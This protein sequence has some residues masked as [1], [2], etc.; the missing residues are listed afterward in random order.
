MS[1]LE[2]S[3]SQF[4]QLADR[5]STL[6]EQWLT[7]L[8]ARSVAPATTGAS[9]QALFAE[10]LPEAGLKDA[11]LEGLG[12]V[13]A[14][15]RAGNARFLGYVCGSGEPVGALGDYLASVLNQNVTAWRSAPAMVSLERSVVAGLARAVGCEGFTG[16]F[17]GGGSAAN[18]MGLAMAREARAP[19]NEDGASGGVVYA[20]S[21][22]HMS[23]PKAMAL[24]GLGRKN[25]RLIPTDAKWRMRP[26]VL[27]RA[28]T[29]DLAAGRRPLAVVATAG[30]VHT[31]AVDPLPDVARIA[32]ARNL[33]LHVD[34]AYGAFAAMA[35][36]E[37]FEGLSLADSLSMDAHKWLYQPVDCGVLLF[38]DAG[39]AR[40]AFSFSGDYARVMSADAVEGFAFFDESLELSR[41]ARALKV[42]LSVRYHGLAA[43]REAILRDVENARR[44]EFAV[45]TAPSLQLLA[46]ATLSAVC[47]RYAGAVP[48]LER[49][50]FNARLLVRVNARGRVYL[51]NAVLEERFC[52]RACFVNH[53]TRP[54][55]VDTVVSEVLAA[56]ELELR[57]G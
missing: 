43:F 41:R 19:A 14:G 44:L 26:E 8:D 32:R 3:P 50:A 55:D 25:L 4:R 1:S 48:E 56:A 37:R 54:E 53:R 45:R 7:E 49:N 33:W 15:A 20:S 12:P 47:F 10:G 31:G 21:E 52:L 22:V 24:L 2:L 40:R 46:P 18:L 30:T 35:L 38:R 11:A 36:P 28:I 16:S 27:E 23:I 42:W 6:A 57:N 9:T 51:S 13:M 17:T 29:E 5:I 39:A 34:G